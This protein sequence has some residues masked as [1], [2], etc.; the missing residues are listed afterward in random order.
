MLCRILPKCT[1]NVTRFSEY[2]LPFLVIFYK[3]D[4]VGRYDS[5]DLSNWKQIP[6]TQAKLLER[7]GG[8]L[9]ILV[10]INTWFGI[11]WVQTMATAV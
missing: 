7:V 2:V 11:S 9:F 3:Y 10:W 4:N 1:Y 5:T 8:S 6:T